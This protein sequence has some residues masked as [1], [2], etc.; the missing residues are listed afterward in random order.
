MKNWPKFEDIFSFQPPTDN[1]GRLS[2]EAINDDNLNLE[3]DSG[4]I[5]PLYE[6]E[7]T[8]T[9]KETWQ[10]IRFD[11]AIRLLISIPT[12][13]ACIALWMGGVLKSLAPMT[14]VF[15]SFAIGQIL[16]T[17][18]FMNN[19]FGRKLEFIMSTFDLISVSFAVYFTGGPGS[20]LYF[21]YFIPLLVHAFHRDWALVL[22][23]GVGGC[24]LYAS[25]ILNSLKEYSSVEL[26]NLGARLFF[27]LL[28]LGIV[29]FA[30][31]LLRKKDTLDRARLNRLRVLTLVGR[32]LN[33][34]STM[35]E[36]T[37]AVAPLIKL[38]NEGLG[39]QLDTWTRFLLTRDDPSTL[40]AIVDEANSRPDL[41]QELPTQTCPAMK[42]GKPFILENREKSM[43]CPVE[44][45][46]F[47]AHVCIP[48][49]GSENE[50]F[51][52]LFAGSSL[53]NAF[54]IE[55]MQFL[56]HISR[57]L[58]LSLQRLQRMEELKKA[59]EMNS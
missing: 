4:N 5:S 25:A 20:P 2:F 44:N 9:Y 10:K 53:P 54:K 8:F 34:I 18:F 40:R 30:V 32:R 49:I 45:F 27:M 46:N 1:H 59:V 11:N 6:S 57:S 38:V 58:A 52:I 15:C 26:T 39:P 35:T 24:V 3:D 55:E 14:V 50:S 13:L 12:Y 29:Y 16:V 42:S 7:Q 17:W 31:S 22:F 41:K 51:G 47:G 37:T 21:I 19:R 48:V 36:L 43:E 28:T 33:K 23:N 56:Q